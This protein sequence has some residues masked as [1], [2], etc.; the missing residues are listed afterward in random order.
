M[1]LAVYASMVCAA[2]LALAVAPAAFSCHAATI[3]TKADMRLWETVADRSVPISWPWSGA[4]DCAVL[5]FSNRLT[6]AVSSA[7]IAR[8]EGA[9]HG[10]CAHPVSDAA[11]AIVDVELLQKTAAGGVLVRDVATL[12]YVSG[13]GGGPITVRARGTREWRRVASPR[14]FAFD[15]A[16]LEEPGESGYDVAW[17]RYRGFV[18]TAR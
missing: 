10:C 11:E 16:W 5:V 1:R 14:V 7:N 3:L 9:T 4:A 12:A 17:P 6:G 18:L 13:E 8:G 2:C 15:P